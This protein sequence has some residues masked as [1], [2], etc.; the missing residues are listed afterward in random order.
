MSHYSVCVVIPHESLDGKISRASVECA[1]GEIMEPYWEETEDPRFAVF[2]DKTEEAKAEYPKA[3][4]MAIK[5]PDGRIVPA[6]S[7]EFTEKFDL[8]D[9][10]ILEKDP[11]NYGKAHETDASRS[12]ELVENYPISAFY[13]FEQYCKDYCGYLQ[14]TGNTWGYVHNPNAEWDWYEIGG[15]FAGEF[16][17]LKECKDVVLCEEKDG[18]SNVPDG[19]Q[20]VDGARMK[21]IVWEK[22]HELHI[23]GVKKGYEMLKKAFE[24]GNAKD[25]PFFATLTDEG[26][27]GWCEMLFTKDETLEQ[28]MANHG[29]T[30][31]DQMPIGTY[32]FI[33]REG[34]WHARGEMGWFGISSNDMPSRDWH[35]EL[36]TMSRLVEPE[37]VLVCVDCH[38]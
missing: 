12:L 34:K 20:A 16:L 21:D 11:K 13:S 26:I 23:E 30:E 10:K 17:V 8:R 18:T 19:Y 2:C 29:A 6:F 5:Y 36:A 14:A 27:A 3:T 28:Y 35:D 4:T 15:R 7:K 37:D 38:I 9:G 31:A 25:L 32:A 22:E 24:T 33:D 1:L